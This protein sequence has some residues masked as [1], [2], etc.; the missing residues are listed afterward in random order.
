MADVVYFSD[1]SRR[2]PGLGA[3]IRLGDAEICVVSFAANGVRVR[4]HR[5]LWFGKPIFI[6]RDTFRVGLI[7]DELWQEFPQQTTPPG[8]V[9]FA[10]IAFSQAI[11]SCQTC[12]EVALVLNAA[13]QRARL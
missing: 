13:R 7:A 9:T 4:R 8:M 2:R 1:K 3:T 6:E 12:A 11:L 5:L 10:L